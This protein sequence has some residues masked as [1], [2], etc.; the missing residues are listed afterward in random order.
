MGSDWRFFSHGRRKVVSQ[1]FCRR[2]VDQKDVDGVVGMAADHRKTPHSLYLMSLLLPPLEFR[3]GRLDHRH[4]RIHRVRLRQPPERQRGFRPPTGLKVMQGCC[5]NA[6][7]PS[8]AKNLEGR[9]NT[10][11]TASG[12][13]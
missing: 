1:Q 5:K 2:V 7:K 13:A 12:S 8:V 11:A 10:V 4:H 3:L 6:A 9:I